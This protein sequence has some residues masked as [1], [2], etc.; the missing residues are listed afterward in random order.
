MFLVN[1]SILTEGPDNFMPIDVHYG[2]KKYAVRYYIHIDDEQDTTITR[3]IAGN[4]IDIKYDLKDKSPYNNLVVVK[5]VNITETDIDKNDITKHYFGKYLYSFDGTNSYIQ[6]PCNQIITLGQTFTI[7]IWFRTV[8]Y[9]LEK[10]IGRTLFIL[11]NNDNNISL[12]FTTNTGSAASNMPKL[13]ETKNGVVTCIGDNSTQNCADGEWQNITITRTATDDIRFFINGIMIT[14]TNSD[15]NIGLDLDAQLVIGRDF[16]DAGHFKGDIDQVYILNGLCDHS[17]DS[18]FNVLKVPYLIYEE[19]LKNYSGLTSHVKL[20]ENVSKYDLLYYDSG[21]RA[22][23]ISNIANKKTIPARAIALE[24]GNYGSTIEVLNYGTISSNAS[25]L[26]KNEFEFNSILPP[27]TNMLGY[28]S[29]S[30]S[31]TSGDPTV[32]FDKTDPKTELPSTTNYWAPGDTRGQ[33]HNWVKIKLDKPK[34]LHSYELKSYDNTVNPPT[35]WK[36]KGS[37]DNQNW[38]L[39]DNQINISSW[40]TY[41]TKTFYTLNVDKTPYQ[42]Y[43]FYDCNAEAINN[44]YLYD[45]NH[46]E[47]LPVMDTTIYI[48]S[49][50]SDDGNNL[51]W[52]CRDGNNSTY[53]SPLGGKISN[54]NLDIDF[55]YIYEQGLYD[56]INV[57]GFTLTCDN[58]G[59]DQ[60]FVPKEFIFQGSNDNINFDDLHTFNISSAFASP[61]TTYGDT[62]KFSLSNMTHYRYYRLNIVSLIEILS[63]N[64]PTTFKLVDIQLYNGD[65][66]LLQDFTS[67]K[68]IAN[69]GDYCVIIDKPISDNDF[70]TAFDFSGSGYWYIS[71]PTFP[72]SFTLDFNYP[73]QLDNY[74]FKNNSSWTN[75]DDF[76]KH[77][78]VYGSDDNITFTELDDYNDTINTNSTGIEDI[79]RNLSHNT[80]YQYYKFEVLDT[81]N[82]TSLYINIIKFNKNR[83]NSYVP[84]VQFIGNTLYKV[85]NY[86]ISNRASAYATATSVRNDHYNSTRGLL[87][88]QWLFNS[89]DSYHYQWLSDD[90][91]LN[92]SISIHLPHLLHTMYNRNIDGYVIVCMQNVNNPNSYRYPSEWTVEGYDGINWIQIDHQSNII[93]NFAGEKKKFNLSATYNNFI[94]IRLN[95]ISTG[96]GGTVSPPIFIGLKAF[97]PT[98]NGCRLEFPKPVHP[99]I[100]FS[101][102]DLKYLNNYAL[103]N[104]NGT[105]EIDCSSNAVEDTF[106]N[107]T[108]LSAFIYSDDAWILSEYEQYPDTNIL[109]SSESRTND[110]A[111]TAIYI[112]MNKSKRLEAYG[113]FYSPLALSGYVVPTT[114]WKLYGSND[115]VNWDL[116]DEQSPIDDIEVLKSWPLVFKIN[117]TK[118]YKLY[119]FDN[120]NGGYLSAIQLY[121]ANSIKESKTLTG[122]ISNPGKVATYDSLSVYNT[123]LVNHYVQ[124]IGHTCFKYTTADDEYLVNFFNFNTD[125]T[126]VNASLG[127]L[128]INPGDPPVGHNIENGPIVTVFCDRLHVKNGAILIPQ[129]PCRGLRI[130][131]KGNCIIDGIISMTAMG[132]S[133]TPLWDTDFPIYTEKRDILAYIPRYGAKGGECL[134][135]TGS[136]ATNPN[137]KRGNA[138]ATS[139][140]YI[141]Q[142][143]N[144]NNGIN[145]ATGGGGSGSVVSYQHFYAKAGNGG[146]GNCFCGGAGGGG[147]YIN[148]N[149]VNISNPYRRFT[150]IP[151]LNDGS[152]GG[153]SLSNSYSNIYGV[154]TSQVWNTLI[155]YASGAGAI[156]GGSYH[157]Y[158]NIFGSR[159][160]I[161]TLD[162]NTNRPQGVGAGGLIILIVYGSLRIN[163]TGKIESNGVTPPPSNLLCTGGS[164][165]GGSIN[166]FHGGSFINNGIIEANGGTIPTSTIGSN[167]MVDYVPGGLGGNGSITIQRMI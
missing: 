112:G 127:L 82:S 163:L 104:E 132:A 27:Y 157:G 30:V 94:E 54:I 91:I 166:I 151:G 80:K 62:V 6:S 164:S 148:T 114:Q 160:N 138:S 40:Y 73:V 18:V 24:D 124:D 4:I 102:V 50:D 14:K 79:N 98:Y 42:Y 92:P 31:A 53:W 63:G 51:I 68:G 56:F 110:Y 153:A 33:P 143:V 45:E 70:E 72:V 146:Q 116:I 156:V 90:N 89:V 123:N 8:T 78:K 76:P 126:E 122:S 84:L 71:N 128:E 106:I 55:G 99:Y 152:L 23:K 83:F 65:I 86:F 135:L 95:I 149:A 39:L 88:N 59:F 130:I 101:Y 158:N 32:L 144:G 145:R 5:S 67:S 28:N 117:T 47:L 150:G 36:L 15:V 34:Y 133:Y 7:A 52:H 140:Q 3:D 97:Y 100:P 109:F 77:V 81:Y 119:K 115:N 25:D 19:E 118:S 159:S 66:P 38:V 43:E 13:F 17:Q 60:I 74:E 44:I 154:N 136:D 1:G 10:S 141:K 26:S 103:G 121:E 107:N 108:I 96:I 125:V 147:Q 105:F 75:I 35:T 69:T 57:D 129:V 58:T 111:K 137:F 9:S 21:H 22:W 61:W 131:V 29:Y 85:C 139:Y 162:P 93:F 134:P 142:G 120:M 49:P 37:N 87:Y 2:F 20:A 46:I 48:S 16:T 167:P 113:I 155:N 12:K 165:G 11:G 41:E 161:T 64:L